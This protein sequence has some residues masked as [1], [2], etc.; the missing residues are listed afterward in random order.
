MSKSSYLLEVHKV[1]ADARELADKIEK[2]GPNEITS[3]L[4][5]PL[6]LKRS[7][8]ALFLRMQKC[9]LFDAG[10]PVCTDQLP[11]VEIEKIMTELREI[12][13]QLGR[14][15]GLAPS[16]FADAISVLNDDSVGE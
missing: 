2:E 11:K 9:R 10:V 12:S 8:V 15:R 14:L 5:A 4:I 1:T 13:G 6:L 7:K 3:L 16:E